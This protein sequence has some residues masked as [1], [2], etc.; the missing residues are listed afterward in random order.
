LPLEF[1]AGENADT[2]GLSG[3]EVINILGLSN[4]LEPQSFVTVEAIQQDG[5]VIRFQAKVRL[6][7]ELEVEYFRNGGIL[8][9]VLRNMI[10][11]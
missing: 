4:A 1:L 2:L 6:D 9:T 5:N 3:E 7:T 11:G 10:S 8:H